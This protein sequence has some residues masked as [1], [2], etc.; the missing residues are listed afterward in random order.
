MAHEINLRTVEEQNTTESQKI[1][2]EVLQKY[3]RNAKNI[4]I[5]SSELADAIQQLG[6]TKPS[7][8]DASGFLWDLWMVVIDLA[9][10]IPPD[11]LWQDILTD[12]IQTLQK[13]GGHVGA[14]EEMEDPLMWKDLPHL[15]NYLLDSW[16]GRPTSNSMFSIVRRCVSKVYANLPRH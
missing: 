7:R 4:H 13:S 2:F 6:A 16:F 1:I 10:L 5:N 15:A 11:H 14:T 12:A 8:D 3:M 9:Y